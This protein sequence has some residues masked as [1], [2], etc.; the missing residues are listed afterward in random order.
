MNQRNGSV[1]AEC[2]SRLHEV[3]ASG[4]LCVQRIAGKRR[5]RAGT[6][7]APLNPHYGPGG[8]QKRDGKKLGEGGRPHGGAIAHGGLVALRT[9]G[10]GWEVA[11][12][13]PSREKRVLTST[14]W[15]PGGIDEKN[16]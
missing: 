12:T 3:R 13:I 7:P 9:R 5:K 2:L 4:A 11:R 14:Q 6:I 1:I 15:H 10:G 8:S 16:K